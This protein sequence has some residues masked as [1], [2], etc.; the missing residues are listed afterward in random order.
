MLLVMKKKV[1]FIQQSLVGGGAERVLVDVLNNFDTN[2]YDVNLLLLFNEGV[3][4]D[5]I[6]N[7]IKQVYLFESAKSL[8]F[9]IFKKLPKKIQKKYILRYIDTYYDVIVSFMEGWTVMI[10]NIVHTCSV[11]NISW[12]HTNL[13]TNNWPLKCGQ[14]KNDYDEFCYYANI[15]DIVFVSSEAKHAFETIAPNNMSRK[16]VIYNLINTDRILSLSGCDQIEKKKFTICSVGRLVEAKRY[17]RLLNAMHILIKK[18]LNIDCWII[19][20][21]IMEESLRQLAKMLNLENVV[22]F[23]GFQRNPY[24][25]MNAADLFVLS[26]DSEGYPTVICESLILGTPVVST[27]V[28]GVPELL[29][30]SEYGL[31]TDLSP[32]SIAE[33]IETL[34]VNREELK[35]LHEQ[36]IKR[37]TI[38]NKVNVMNNIYSLIND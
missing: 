38:F 31:L 19:G 34:Y 2:K 36:A 21:G 15:N 20:Q 8:K 9:R 37:S 32:E 10:H 22:H 4:T 35:L 23:W 24:P 28:T 30:D 11:R 5:D 16:H 18:G 14:F 13:K 29:G 25:Y 3:Y 33:S 6:S 1:L 7:E 26:S 27:R 12:I 17:D